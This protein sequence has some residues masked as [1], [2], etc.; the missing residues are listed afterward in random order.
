M[1]AEIFLLQLENE[2]RATQRAA[3]AIRPQA[4]PVPLIV[5]SWA[6]RVD[7]LLSVCDKARCLWSYPLK[8]IAK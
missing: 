2:L 7:R 5:Y 3:K 8:H 6:S 1:L 4:V